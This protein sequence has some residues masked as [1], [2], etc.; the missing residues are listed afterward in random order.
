MSSLLIWLSLYWVVSTVAGL[1]IFGRETGY[2]T[3]AEVA[4]LLL[5]AWAIVPIKVL[6]ESANITVWK[7]KSDDE[8]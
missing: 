7:R 3:L 6:Q 5:L 8:D 1:I 4:M 2:L